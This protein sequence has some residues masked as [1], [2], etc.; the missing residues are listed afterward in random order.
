MLINMLM[1]TDRCLWV[2]M[3]VHG[4]TDTQKIQNHVMWTRGGAVMHDLGFPGDREISRNIMFPCVWKKKKNEQRTNSMCQ[5][6]HMS[7]I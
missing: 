2:R 7:L 6:P 3:G 1:G 4:C 5:D